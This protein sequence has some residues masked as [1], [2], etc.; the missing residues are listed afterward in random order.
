M[1]LS[2]DLFFVTLANGLIGR[3][4]Q[5]RV[6]SRVGVEVSGSVGRE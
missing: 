3:H 2:V 4:F 1:I 5:V 6:D